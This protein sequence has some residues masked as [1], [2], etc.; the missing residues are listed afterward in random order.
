MALNAGVTLVV[1]LIALAVDRQFIAPKM[2]A[3]ATA[4]P[5][6]AGA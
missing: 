5:A 6:T 1:V 2:K 3:K 4:S